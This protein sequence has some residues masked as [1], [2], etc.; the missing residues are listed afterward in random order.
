MIGIHFIE[1]YLLDRLSKR[2]CNIA[3]KQQRLK[4]WQTMIQ[5]SLDSDIKPMVFSHMQT[6]HESQ[7]TK[8]GISEK[9]FTAHALIGLQNFFAANPDKFIDR[10]S[11]GPPPAYR[12]LAWKFMADKLT[13]KSKRGKKGKYL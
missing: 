7:P 6:V 1:A 12:W 8:G 5:H 13:E 4:K 11:K 10:L 9:Y 3:T 2:E